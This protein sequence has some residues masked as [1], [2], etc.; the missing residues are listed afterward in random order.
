MTSGARRI[1][2][3]ATALHEAP[4]PGEARRL[5]PASDASQSTST[6][7][8]ACNNVQKDVA[9]V[10]GRLRAWQALHKSRTTAHRRRE[11]PRTRGIDHL[12]EPDVRRRGRVRLH[13]HKGC[14]KQDLELPIV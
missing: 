11:A 12:V 5:D 7:P 14:P 8:S 13:T 6:L 10:R 9:L 3:R 1:R 4:R 2:Q